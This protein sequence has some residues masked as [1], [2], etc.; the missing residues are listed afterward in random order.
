MSGVDTHVQYAYVMHTITCI[1]IHNAC[2]SKWT[3]KQ[4]LRLATA[5]V[6]KVHRPLLSPR[7]FHL[8]TALD[9]R[10]GRRRAAACWDAQSVGHT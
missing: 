8:E 1:Y 5:I 6:P 3:L 4:S 10:R 2:V 7:P 9:H